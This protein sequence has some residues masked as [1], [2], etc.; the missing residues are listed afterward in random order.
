MGPIN[1]YIGAPSAVS[2]PE[3]GIMSRQV[4]ITL[5]QLLTD[6]SHTILRNGHDESGLDAW[7]TFVKTWDPKT[8]GRS[9]NAYLRLAQPGSALANDP[10]FAI[11]DTR[12]IRPN[13][14]LAP[15]PKQD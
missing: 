4:Y 2:V 8:I 11:L 6:E 5:A 14:D 15:S 9:R 10:C 12:E 1:R 7:R 3:V 13:I